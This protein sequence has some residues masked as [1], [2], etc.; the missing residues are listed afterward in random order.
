MSEVA[1]EPELPP[2]LIDALSAAEALQL[3]AREVAT[4]GMAVK[5][6]AAV[7]ALRAGVSGVRVG[8][9]DMLWNQNAGTT[10]HAEEVACR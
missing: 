9:L 5:L 10:V 1:C 8:P 2:L 6:R 3:I 7:G 4:G